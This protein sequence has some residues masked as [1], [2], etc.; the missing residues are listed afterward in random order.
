MKNFCKR[1]LET[2][3]FEFLI[4]AVILINSATIGVETYYTSGLFAF[5][6]NIALAV[7]T[8][9]IIIRFIAR[10]NTREFFSIGWN[11]FDLFLVLVSFV[12]NTIFADSQYVLLLRLLR[13]FRV[14]RLLRVSQ[15]LKLIIS[16]LLRSV[17]PLAY[18]ISFML[19]FMYLFAIMGTYL[20]KLDPAQA[21]TEKYREFVHE[22]GWE[23]EQPYQNLHTSMFT[24][25]AIMTTDMGFAELRDN[26]NDA[27]EQGLIKASYAAI[28]IFHII[29]FI[30]SVF[31]ILNL[32]LGAVVNNYDT[33]KS[34]FREKRMEFESVVDDAIM[35]G[36]IEPDEEDEVI[37]KGRI[38]GFSNVES[39]K[40]LYRR[41]ENKKRKRLTEII[42]DAVADGIIEEHEKQAVMN[43][44]KI[45]GV[46]EQI[47]LDM[48]QYRLEKRQKHLRIKRERFNKIV[49]EAVAD[50]MITED[51][52]KA[53]IAAAKEAL[54]SEC[55]AKQI[56]KKQLENHIDILYGQ[57][58]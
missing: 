48:L 55:E 20:F 9:E 43:Q 46:R 6:N 5:V 23:E 14:L 53:I 13:I 56:L 41:L 37:E 50:G 30:F 3:W 28:T 44:S 4:I 54:I 42:E 52:Q 16:V 21:N 2:E 8:I 22:K 10:E 49:I 40:I 7:F 12:P 31:M 34:E 32:I 57:A 36:V 11:I 47:A 33:I 51:E 17:K 26:L 25:F 19:I 24:V 29:W 45:A 1:L 15:E 38:A 58:K 18:N 39:E 35:D 27:S